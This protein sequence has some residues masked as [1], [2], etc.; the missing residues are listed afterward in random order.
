MTEPIDPNAEPGYPT[1]PYEPPPPFAPP[2]PYPPNQPAT[3]FGAPSAYGTPP[4]YGTP[5]PYGTPPQYATPPQYNPNALPW[6]QP[7][8]EQPPA[9]TK[10]RNM[11]IAIVAFLVLAAGG[12]TAYAV[13][14]GVNDSSSKIAMPASFDGY[15]KINNSKVESGMREMM[16]GFGG[17]AVLDQASFGFYSK[18]LG[19]RPQLI[20]FAVPSSAI[21]SAQ[22]GTFSTQVQSLVGVV[23]TYPSGPHGGDTECGETQVATVSEIMCAWQDAKTAG[24]MVAI[25]EPITTSQLAKVSRDLRNRID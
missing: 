14:S 6:L 24:V 1:P 22:H 2:Q 19:D 16:S 21:P 4:Q 23:T 11:I 18:D 9:S 20:V 25:L 3:P 8:Q 10:K 15:F 5:S 17:G 13:M 12:V 7:Q